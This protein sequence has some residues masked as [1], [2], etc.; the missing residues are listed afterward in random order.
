M[1]TV[2]YGDRAQMGEYVKKHLTYAGVEQEIFSDN[3]V[4]EIFRFSSG[5][6]RLV[7]K[8]CTH[9][10]LYGSQNKRR[11]I[12]DHMVKLVVQGELSSILPAPYRGSRPAIPSSY[13]HLIP[14]IAGHYVL[15][16]TP[17]FTEELWQCHDQ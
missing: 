2:T 16:V 10:L 4:D 15:V 13:G 3:A 1:Q 6:A 5:T 12:D 9:S 7:N 11:I 17:S 14:S 8:V